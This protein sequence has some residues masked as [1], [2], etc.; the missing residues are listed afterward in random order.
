MSSCCMLVSNG[1]TESKWC[2]HGSSEILHTGYFRSIDKLVMFATHTIQTMFTVL[3]NTRATKCKCGSSLQCNWNVQS[4]STHTHT[5]TPS[6]KF[7]QINTELQVCVPRCV[8][9]TNLGLDVV[10]WGHYLSFY[11]GNKLNKIEL[12]GNCWRFFMW[13]AY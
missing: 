8:V 7:L 9:K 12:G 6:P 3:F 2:T 10:N 1:C 11:V 5:H 13:Q 4:F